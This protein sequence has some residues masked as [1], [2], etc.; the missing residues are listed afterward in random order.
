MVRKGKLLNK[1]NRYFKKRGL[2]IGSRAVISPWYEV[3][4]FLR[5]WARRLMPL[6]AVDALRRMMINRGHHYFSQEG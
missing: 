4:I 2:D 1:A 6:W 3:K 5:T